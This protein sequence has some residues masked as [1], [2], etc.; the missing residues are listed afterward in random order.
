MMKLRYNT[1]RVGELFRLNRGVMGLGKVQELGKAKILTSSK[2]YPIVSRPRIERPA[3]RHRLL[4]S[5][6]RDM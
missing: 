6:H 5:N 2:A 3:A 1:S 4:V